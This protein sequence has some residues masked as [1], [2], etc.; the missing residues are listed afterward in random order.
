MPAGTVDYTGAYGVYYR[1]IF[2]HIPHLIAKTDLYARF[3]AQGGTA[4]RNQ[5][6]RV[7][8]KP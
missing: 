2:F 5:P 7:H 4:G 3:Q 1:E 6:L 8:D